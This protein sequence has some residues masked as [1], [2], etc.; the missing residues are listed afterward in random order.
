MTAKSK[1]SAKK[2]QKKKAAKVASKEASTKLDVCDPAEAN[3]YLDFEN[4][5]KVDSKDKLE[6]AGSAAD[7]IRDAYDNPHQWFHNGCAQPD[8]RRKAFLV[9]R[10]WS[11]TPEKLWALAEAGIPWMAINEY[12]EDGPKPQFWCSGDPPVYFPERLWTDPEVIKFCAMTTKDLLRPR[13]DAYHPALRTKDSPNTHF[14]HAVQNSTD[15]VSWLHTP[16]INWGTSL[17]AP[18]VPYLYKASARSSMLIGLRLLWHFGYREVYLLGCDC[19]P[20]HH[21]FPYY[22]ETIMHHVDTIAPYFGRYGYSVY[23]T[24]ECSHMR[25]FPIVPFVDALAA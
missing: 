18:D 15:V 16:W 24:N 1:K 23:Q 8:D 6:I 17:C 3:A 12:P 19:T 22:W 21:D 2:R 7:L 9:G 20:H 5:L 11:R 14:F 25:Q 4:L 10:G 13:V